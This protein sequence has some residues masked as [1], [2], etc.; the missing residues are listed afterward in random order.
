MNSWFYFSS[1]DN[2]FFSNG[3]LRCK[4]L[5]LWFMTTHVLGINRTAETSCF[6]NSFFEYF[7]SPSKNYSLF[8][9]PISQRDDAISIQ[10]MAGKKRVIFIRDESELKYFTWTHPLQLNCFE[11]ISGWQ[12][13][14][15]WN[16]H[17]LH[18]SN[19]N[20]THIKNHKNMC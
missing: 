7:F 2:K 13:Y 4:F 1:F 14:G 16:N 18:T 10:F 15:N 20:T 3:S 5:C 12:M 6:C 8:P 17:K 19:N 11:N 9:I